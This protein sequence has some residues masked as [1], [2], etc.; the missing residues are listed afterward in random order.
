MSNS[1][2]LN[3][4]QLK[5]TTTENVKKTKQ[6]KEKGKK[7]KR[8]V[9]TA[10]LVEEV[11]VSSTQK[12]DDQKWGK[13]YAIDGKISSTYTGFYKSGKGDTA[14]WLQLKLVSPQIVSG[15][16]VVNRAD[17][18]GERLKKLEI[19]A[20]MKPVPDGKGKPL[21]T[22]NERVAFF[23]GPGV[24]GKTHK[25]IFEKPILAQYITLQ[26]TASKTLQINEVRVLVQ[27]MN[28]GIDQ[29]YIN[30]EIV[31]HIIL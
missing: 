16:E 6:K 11:M 14:P 12:N 22:Q 8:K 15:L 10:A 21:L 7:K 28:S 13:Q 26:L 19:R 5:E 2:Y 30:L 18:G 1:L 27:R 23:D 3:I 24:T 29:S 17:S 4:F 20:G 25:I 9:L 31:L